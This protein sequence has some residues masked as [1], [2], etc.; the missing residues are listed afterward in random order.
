MS[1]RKVLSKYYPP[2]FDPSKITRTKGPKVAGPKVQT[3]RL[4]AVRTPGLS[5]SK[6][7][8]A[9]SLEICLG[10]DIESTAVRNEMH[11]MRRVH[12]QRKEIQ[13]PKRDDRREVSK[14]PHLPVLHTLYSMFW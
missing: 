5:T 6:A 4:M 7:G 12:L 3:V 1:E 2:D 9:S 8:S 14:H 11:N 10:T 13:R